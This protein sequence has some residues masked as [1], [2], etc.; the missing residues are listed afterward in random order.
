M[1]CGIVAELCIGSD[2]WHLRGVDGW[3]CLSVADTE[4]CQALPFWP[5]GSKCC[6]LINVSYGKQSVLPQNARPH[7][8]EL[9]A[10][11]PHGRKGWGKELLIII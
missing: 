4:A 8:A 6:Q 10:D 1:C 5:L 11:T 7:F 9:D 3:F 2:V